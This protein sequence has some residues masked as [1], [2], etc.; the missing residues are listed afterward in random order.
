MQHCTVTSTCFALQAIFATGA[1][2][3]TLFVD[4]V[5]ANMNALDDAREASTLDVDTM[6]PIRSIMESLLH[7][8]WCKEDMSQVPLL[9]YT[10]L[11]IDCNRLFLDYVLRADEGLRSRFR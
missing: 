8:N 4:V 1:S 9:L 10:S 7:A 2:C 3:L 11:R 6:I 5:N